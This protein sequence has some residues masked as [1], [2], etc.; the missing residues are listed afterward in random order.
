MERDFSSEEQQAVNR[1]HSEEGGDVNQRLHVRDVEQLVEE[2]F[3]VTEDVS[4]TQAIHLYQH[5]YV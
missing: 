5:L 2:D 3:E 4:F 1:D